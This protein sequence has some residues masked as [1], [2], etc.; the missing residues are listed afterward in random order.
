MVP[1]YGAGRASRGSELLSRFPERGNLL[2]LQRYAYVSRLALVPDIFTPFEVP[3][4]GLMIWSDFSLSKNQ[5]K[6][7]NLLWVLCALKRS[8]LLNNRLVIM[9]CYQD[10][11]I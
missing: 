8:S 9:S 11:C 3:R 4:Q 6:L 1:T 2:K 5:A 10:V 7:K